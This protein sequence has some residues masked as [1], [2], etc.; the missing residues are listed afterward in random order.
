MTE[1][2]SWYWTRSR[3]LTHAQDRARFVSNG[4]VLDAPFR[5]LSRA[6]YTGACSRIEATGAVMIVLIAVAWS[7]CLATTRYPEVEVGD[8][9]HHFVVRARDE[10]GA[11]AVLGHQGGGT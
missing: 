2:D 8:D 1:E 6:S 9:A 5:I 4:E 7:R 10:D 3:N 11:G